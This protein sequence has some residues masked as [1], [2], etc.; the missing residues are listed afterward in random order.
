MVARQECPGGEFAEDVRT[1]YQ[2]KRIDVDRRLAGSRRADDK[3]PERVSLHL[4]MGHSA[5]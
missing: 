3:E 1:R 2:T 5:G 4:R